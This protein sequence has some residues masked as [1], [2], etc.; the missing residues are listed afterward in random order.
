M[1]SLDKYLIYIYIYIH[2]FHVKWVNKR[3]Y[4]I[5]VV[6]LQAGIKHCIYD[7]ECGR[8][9][10]RRPG[11]ALVGQHGGY[12]TILSD[13]TVICSATDNKHVFTPN[14]IS[15]HR[16]VKCANDMVMKAE[17]VS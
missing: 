17:E 5:G 10:E 6:V 13:Q 4:K 11:K 15:L 7:L 14:I 9:S 3:W 1:K 12:R 8:L 16:K 2:L